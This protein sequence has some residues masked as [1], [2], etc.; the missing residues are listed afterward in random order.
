[1]LNCLYLH[2]ATR[3]YMPIFIFTDTE[4]FVFDNGVNLLSLS[5]F[6]YFYARVISHAGVYARIR[7]RRQSQSH[8]HRHRPRYTC[9]NFVV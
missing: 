7:R 6:F 4:L 8:R 3:A 1:M 5:S 2:N 9:W